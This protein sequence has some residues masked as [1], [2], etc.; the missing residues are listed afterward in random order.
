MKHQKEESA[1][2]PRIHW[3]PTGEFTFLPLHAA[4]V[5][6]GAYQDSLS[7]YVVSSY[8]PTISAL[9]RARATPICLTPS[10]TQLLLVAEKH[11][12]EENMPILPSVDAECDVVAQAAR[13]ASAS[14]VK[15]LSGAN[16]V[17]GVIGD[18]SSANIVHMACHGVQSASDALSSGFCLR[19]GNLTVS[20]LMGMELSQAFLAFLS[21]CE[22]AK[23]DAKQ[24][25]QTVH[26][27]A[28]M[29]FAGF[30]SVIATMW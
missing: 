19:D 30:R 27:A 29:L 20:Q 4:G 24:P 9:L 16:S 23:G 10:S 5:Y 6:E 12:K 3:C 21:A 22:T 28:A 7:N 2:R 15:R 11:A 1:S 25:D 18:A 8:T 14:F 17:S 13:N 26:L